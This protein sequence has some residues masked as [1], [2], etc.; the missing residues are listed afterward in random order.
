MDVEVIFSSIKA[1][2]PNASIAL[3]PNAS[4]SRQ[5]SLLIA[6]ADFLNIARWLRDHPEHAFD[7]LSNLTGIDY[8]DR[9][10]KEKDQNSKTEKAFDKTIPGFLEVVYHLYSTRHRRGPLVL[11][12]R[13]ANRIDQSILPSVTPLWRSAEFQEREVF[14][15]FGVHFE[16]HPDL[17]RLLMWDEFEGHPMRKDYIDPD[18]FE[19]EPTAHGS[20]LKRANAHSSRSN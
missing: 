7:Y 1:R 3:I 19:Y 10:V 13:T 6:P 12:M 15:L 9:I 2:F 16:G 20:V 8:L 5:S 4:P 18:D 14:D 17:R 11:R